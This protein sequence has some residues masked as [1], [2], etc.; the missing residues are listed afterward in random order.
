M[1]TLAKPLAYLSMVALF[2]GAFAVAPAQ[3]GPNHDSH[4]HAKKH[5]RGGMY[6]LKKLDLSDEQKAEVKSI[7]KNAKEQ[8]KGLHESLKAYKQALRDLVNSPDYSE[9]AV[10]SLHAQYQSVFADKVVIKANAS[11]QINALLTPEQQAKKAEIKAKMKARWAEKK[12]RMKERK[13][14]QS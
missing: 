8:K 2:A 7:M 5:D 12:K 11:H 10:R 14:D 13:A 4:K 9:Q 3:A 6:I 1:N